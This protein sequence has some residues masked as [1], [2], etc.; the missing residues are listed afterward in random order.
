MV[1]SE[2]GIPAV[3]DNR[4]ALWQRAVG[5][6]NWGHLLL[7][8]LRYFATVAEEGSVL[9]AAS[10][11]RI[12]Q[13]ALSRQIRQLEGYLGVPLFERE[14]HGVRITGAGQTL[15]DGV[16]R[17]S[18]RL[19]A[20]AHHARRA[21]RG[22]LGTVRIGLVRGPMDNPRIAVAFHTVRDRLPDVELVLTELPHDEDVEALRSGAVDI[23]LCVGFEAR[24]EFRN[25]VLY[26]TVA[27]SVLL[28]VNYHPNED[29]PIAPERL[30]PH[31]GWLVAGLVPRLPELVTALD[32]L[33]LGVELVSSAETAAALVETGRGWTV[34]SSFARSSAPA[35]TSVVTVHGLRVEIPIVAITRSTDDS[36]LL[37]NVRRILIAAMDDGAIPPVPDSAGDEGLPVPAS[38]QLELRQLRAFTVA[39]EE[40]SLTRAARRLGLSQSAISRQIKGLERGVG[41][42]LLRR[43]IRDVTPTVAGQVF[44]EESK[45]VLSIVEGA[46]R[47]ARRVARGITGTCIIGTVPAEL[48][49][50]LLVSK[51]AIL[52]RRHPEVAIELCEMSARAQI[53]SLRDRKTDVGIAGIRRQ[54][55]DDANVTSVV[56]TDDPIECALLSDS[57][58]LATRAW[59][60]PGDLSGWPFLFIP[61]RRNASL[62]DAVI[63][64]LTEAG[65]VPNSGG[66]FDGPRLLWN[67]IAA[68]QGW[69]IACR[70]LRR[71]PP[72]GLV[73]VPLEGLSIPWG[74]SLFW[75]SDELD[76]TVR[77][78]LDVFRDGTDSRVA[79]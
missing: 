26:T 78:V 48:T 11:L 65:I 73:A 24:P 50:G 54:D 34:V 21:D 2:I 61:R 55:V 3:V 56:L 18:I 31:K 8:R 7:R 74:L 46:V 13:P 23:A 9:R 58:P 20:A 41:C 16:Q 53:A 5:G 66:A 68:S 59:L 43:P 10:R 27:D 71:N 15:L 79:M 62:Y 45:A 6:V 25:D 17:V 37:A 36:H 12:A 67:A 76:E 14:R 38:A 40:R 28:P 32:R 70:S 77:K 4:E 42:A 75:R 33:G 52:T 47:R 44:K 29:G 51:L 72:R 22:L 64:G 39:L 69:A 60:R 19:D 63:K 30:Q 1:V 49:N 57:H 35:G